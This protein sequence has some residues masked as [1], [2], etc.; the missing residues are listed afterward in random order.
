MQCHPQPLAA[1]S[2]KLVL[3]AGLRGDDHLLMDNAL[4]STAHT[5][6]H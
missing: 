4:A 2:E 6:L 3:E 1:T 5:G